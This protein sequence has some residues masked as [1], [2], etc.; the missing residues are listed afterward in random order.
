LIDFKASDVNPEGEFDLTRVFKGQLKSA[1]RKFIKVSD[2]KLRVEDVLE[3]SD[4]TKTVTWAMM[5]QAD[6][7]VING[8]ILLTQ[9]GKTLKVLLKQPLDAAIKIVSKDPPP[10]AYDMKVPGLKR[11][12]FKITANSLMASGSK[13]IVELTGE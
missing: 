9:N 5:T 1:K 6:A 4:Q 3:L 13:I 11:L 7:Q 8:G 10:L 2:H 12:E